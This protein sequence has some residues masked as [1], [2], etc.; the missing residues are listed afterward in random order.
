METPKKP[1]VKITIEADEQKPEKGNVDVKKSYDQ[2]NKKLSEKDAKD[3]L[4]LFHQ[5]MTKQDIAYL[6]ERQTKSISRFI[7]RE[8]R[9]HLFLDEK[10]W[11]KLNSLLHFCY[12]STKVPQDLTLREF[13]EDYPN[14]HLSE[15][16]NIKDAPD[17]WPNFIRNKKMMR[18]W[19]SYFRSK[20]ECQN[21]FK[22]TP[23]RTKS[24]KFSNENPTNEEMEVYREGGPIQMKH[25]NSI[26]FTLE[27]QK[28]V[29]EFYEKNIKKD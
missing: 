13:F 16:L 18:D 10:E 2:K 25:L 27:K 15:E 4:D 3:F 12:L 6:G 9:K 22:N 20:F 7:D 5:G 1:E 28:E 21:R 23:D 11:G 19:I 14:E 17:H 26:A 29:R 24:D 8:V